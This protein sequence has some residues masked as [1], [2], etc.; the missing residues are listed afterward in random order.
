MYSWVE[1]YWNLYTSFKSQERAIL[2]RGFHLCGWVKNL[3][4]YKIKLFFPNMKTFPKP[5]SE[6]LE[7]SNYFQSKEWKQVLLLLKTTCKNLEMS[8]Q[9]KNSYMYPLNMA[10]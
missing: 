9:V 7:I 3:V 10:K 4:I 8:A 2:G 6:L 5:I 1:I